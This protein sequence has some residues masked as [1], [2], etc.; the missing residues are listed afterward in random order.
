MPVRQCPFRAT[1]DLKTRIGLLATACRHI[2]RLQSG[3]GH[4]SRLNSSALVMWYDNKLLFNDKYILTIETFPVLSGSGLS[5]GT[6][7]RPEIQANLQEIN[8]SLR[9]SCFGVLLFL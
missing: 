5:K 7:M 8:S 1:S 4:F 9:R 6:C 2:S 3:P